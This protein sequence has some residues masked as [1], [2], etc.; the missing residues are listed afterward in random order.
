MRWEK[1]FVRSL[2]TETTL[3]IGIDVVGKL[4][5]FEECVLETVRVQVKI[6]DRGEIRW[7]N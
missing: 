4:C 2:Y 7:K 5:D 1:H 3:C 6:C